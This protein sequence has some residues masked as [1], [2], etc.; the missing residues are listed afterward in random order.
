M[1]MTTKEKM[2]TM[3]KSHIRHYDYD[4]ADL[5]FGAPERLRSQKRGGKK[6]ANEKI[7]EIQRM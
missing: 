5:S 2:K 7:L 1:T 3:P 6:I 4:L